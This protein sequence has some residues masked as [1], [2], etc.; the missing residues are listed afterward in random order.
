MLGYFGSKLNMFRDIFR[1]KWSLGVE[2]G[3]AQRLPCVP[4]GSAG[5]SYPALDGTT[6]YH[7]ILG[8]WEQNRNLGT[9]F[10]T[11]FSV[12]TKFRIE[13]GTTGNFGFQDL[14]FWLRKLKIFCCKIKTLPQAKRHQ[15]H[16]FSLFGLF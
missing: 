15:H 2:A 14:N 13:E 6:F 4:K 7:H 11:L 16:S 5:I 3:V 8:Y 10:L 1:Q 9:Q 12:C